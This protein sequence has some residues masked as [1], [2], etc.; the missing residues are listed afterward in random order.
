MRISTFVGIVSV[1]SIA[2]A[3]TQDPECKNVGG[4]CQ[5]T[6]ISCSGGSYLT[7]YCPSSGNSIKCCV[8]SSGDGIIQDEKCREVGGSCILT[9]KACSA[10]FLSGYCPSSGNNVKCCPSVS[11]GG[12]TQDSQCTNVGGVCQATST[13]CAAGFLTGYCPSSGDSIKCCPSIKQD[14]QCTSAGGK[15]QLTSRSCSGSYVTGLCPSTGDNV[16]C[17]TPGSGGIIQDDECLD[18]GGKCQTTSTSCAGGYV[19]GYCPS[20]GDSIKCCRPTSGGGGGSGSS[21]CG[22]AKTRAALADAAIWTHNSGIAVDYS[23]GNQRWSGITGRRCPYVTN[24]PVA[25]CSSFT[26]WLYWSAFGDGADSLNGQSW[27]AG[28]TGTMKDHGKA[29]SF[30]TAQIGDLVFY[31]DPAHVVILVKKGSTQSASKVVSMGSDGVPKYLSMNYR[32]VS[33]IRTYAAFF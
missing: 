12:V 33:Q 23:Q 25:D 10:G 18:I 26:T 22:I 27:S 24:P 1:V 31:E 21:F 17:C 14:S 29:V 9:S 28:Y 6:S 15:C 30:D 11:G 7:N 2:F 8:P 16:K 5:D 20:S 3:A 4:T 13:S 32:S 19:S